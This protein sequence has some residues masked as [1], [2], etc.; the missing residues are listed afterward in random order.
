MRISLTVTAGPHEGTVFT[1]AG[2]D[3]FIVGRSKRA[4]FRLP[5][6]DRYFSRVHFMIEVNPPHCRL[7]DLKSRNGSYVNGERVTT[8]DLK[9]GDQIKAGKTILRVS[10]DQD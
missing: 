6:K 2:H 1:F 9:H 4:H 3:T 8:A 7:M 10:V 5:V